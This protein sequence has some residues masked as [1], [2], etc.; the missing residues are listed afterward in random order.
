MV[1][2]HGEEIRVESCCHFANPVQKLT[3]PIA[4]VD[5]HNLP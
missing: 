2:Q 5:A 3:L 1:E 4:V